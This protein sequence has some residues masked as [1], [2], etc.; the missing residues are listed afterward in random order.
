MLKRS[1]SSRFFLPI[2]QI[3]E[4]TSQLSIA[5]I[6]L[7]IWPC[8]C[9]TYRPDCA[10][11]VK[12]GRAYLAFGM[13]CTYHL[14]ELAGRIDQSTNTTSGSAKSD[15]AAF[16]QTGHRYQ[17]WVGLSRCICQFG[18]SDGFGVPVLTSDRRPWLNLRARD[19][20]LPETN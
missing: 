10:T 16:D 11:G 2:R 15:T 4:L 19:Q 5:A 3:L 8:T 20:N 17:S 12:H 7:K 14:S 18:R 1:N 9:A 6:A 13:T